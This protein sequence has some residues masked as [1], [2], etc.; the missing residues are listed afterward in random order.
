MDPRHASKQIS[1]ILGRPFIAIANATI[2][3][4]L[5]VLDVSVMNMRVRLNIFKV[6]SRPVF[7]DESKC[8]F[9]DMIDEMCNAPNA[10]VTLFIYT[11]HI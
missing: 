5:G 2:N 3:C 7:E 4:K 10:H 6:S 8:F 1:I 9:V 11:V